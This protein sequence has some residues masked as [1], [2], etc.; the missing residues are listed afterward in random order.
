[1][2]HRRPL[3]SVFILLHACREPEAPPRVSA[4]L[5][6]AVARDELGALAPV[7]GDTPT[8][9]SLREAQLAVRRNPGRTRPLL[10]L[11]QLYVRKAREAS[12]PSLYER[13]DDAVTRALRIDP[14]DLSALQVRGLVL[15][16][17]HRF[18]EARD[19]A[20][21]AIARD[22]QQAIFY[23]LLG[24]AEMEVGH[25]TAAETAYQQMVNLRPNL[26]SYSR[27]SWLRWLIGDPDGAIDLGRHAV[28]AGSPR[29]PEELAWTIVQLG[30]LQ[31]SIGDLAGALTNY[32]A[33]LRVFPNY[34]SALDARGVLR[35]A[36]GDLAGAVSDARLAVLGSTT[37]EHLLHL[38]EA[39]RAAG[40]Q[41]EADSTFAQAERA[42]RRSDPRALS[43]FYANH[44]R[45]QAA[46]VELARRELAA[47]PDEVYSQDALAWAL[48]R[49]GQ[50][51][52]AAVLIDRARRLGTREARFAFHA[53]MIARARRA[54]DA[55][56]TLLCEAL[57]MN[58]YF[59]VDG[60]AEARRALQEMDAGACPEAPRAAHRDAG[61]RD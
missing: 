35:R 19:L 46:A 15:M 33:A 31:F 1:M 3:L 51:D 8:D 12:D 44:N 6:A 10:R 14:N 26:A 25:Y 24:D 11:A 50:L 55:A 13:A 42:G 45:D 47:R 60:V 5:D 43:L 39:Q 22:R 61:L 52:E 48:F 59:D 27:G 38:G 41:A 40:R 58:P 29:V 37:T 49:Q 21:R 28:E 16:Q 36:R 18:A 9:R 23:G 56:R 4:S 2:T 32:E 30:N 53:G 17:D 54:P 7:L 20:T 57:Q 34:P